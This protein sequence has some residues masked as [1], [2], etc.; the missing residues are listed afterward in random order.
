MRQRNK[1]RQG[2]KEH[3]KLEEVRVAPLSITVRRIK[4]HHGRKKQLR[5][6]D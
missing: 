6:A 1:K 2:E 4:Q 5:Q 3:K